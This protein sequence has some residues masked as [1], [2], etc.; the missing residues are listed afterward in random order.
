MIR[1][2]ATEYHA[3]ALVQ[4]NAGLKLIDSLPEV[5]DSGSWTMQFISKSNGSDSYNYWIDQ[6]CQP[7]AQNMPFD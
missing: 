6:I 5:T 3:K 1:I 7:H 2:K 4:K